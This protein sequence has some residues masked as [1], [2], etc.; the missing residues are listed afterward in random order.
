MNNN[1]FK[2]YTHPS[3]V[4][5]EQ[6]KAK[7][8][9]KASEYAQMLMDTDR[10]EWAL[11]CI[12]EFLLS[13]QADL[14]TLEEMKARG[15]FAAAELCGDADHWIDMKS[16]HRDQADACFR[17]IEGLKALYQHATTEAETKAIDEQIDKYTR[18]AYGHRKK[19]GGTRWYQQA[20]IR[21]KMIGEQK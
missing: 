14:K 17:T 7:R 3:M 13:T 5:Y 11:Q 8:L 19:A 15:Y 20:R 4:Y 6:A 18:F 21:S 10:G 16:Y 9:A 1:R 2:A 12:R